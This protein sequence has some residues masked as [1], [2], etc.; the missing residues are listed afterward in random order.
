MVSVDSHQQRIAVPC[1]GEEV[2]PLFG[3][4]RRFRV[5]DIEGGR[6]AHYREVALDDGG[7]LART[8]L[9]RNL[10]VDVILANGIESQLRQLLES[11]GRLVIEGVVGTAT[12]ALYGFLAGRIQGVKFKGH[13]S[14]NRA[15]TAD[16]TSWTEELLREGGWSIRTVH[17]PDIFPVDFVGERPCPICNKP[18]RIAVCCG[19]HAYRVDEEIRE[20][21]RV[22]SANYH[23][24]LYVHQALPSVARTCTEYGIELLPPDRFAELKE[25]GWHNCELPPLRGTIKGHPSLNRFATE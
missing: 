22:T 23:A 1:F 20:F 14:P 16:V 15:Q 8:R 5:W 10:E 11:E 25:G 17:E 24:R 6:V 7:P 2:A 3:V 9:M 19:S 18:V 21:Q 13:T 4:T 12:D